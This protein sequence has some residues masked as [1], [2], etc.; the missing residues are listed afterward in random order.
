VQEFGRKNDD[1]GQKTEKCNAMFTNRGVFGQQMPTTSHN[2]NGFYF[3]QLLKTITNYCDGHFL[4][5]D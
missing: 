2:F 3:S 5:T 1:L 4:F